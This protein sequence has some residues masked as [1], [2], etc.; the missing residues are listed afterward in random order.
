MLWLSEKKRRQ[1]FESDSFQEHYRWCLAALPA[2][3][4]AVL[5]GILIIGTAA[6]RLAAWPAAAAFWSGI[7]L[8]HGMALAAALT[9]LW[10][11]VEPGKRHKALNTGQ[12]ATSV[13]RLIGRA[14]WIAVA[15]Q[16]VS[17]LLLILTLMVLQPFGYTHEASPIIDYLMQHP[18]LINRLS[19]LVA[20]VVVAPVVEELFFRLVLFESMRAN[21]LPAPALLTSLAFALSHQSIAEIPSL[22]VLGLLLQHL[23]KTSGTLWQPIAVHAAFNGA[24]VL[25]LL[26]LPWQLQAAPPA[27]DSEPT[28]MLPA[29]GCYSPGDNS[30]CAHNSAPSGMIALS[31]SVPATSVRP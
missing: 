21:R 6:E 18:A 19:V 9:V 11:H 27:T 8:T 22:L 12:P 26:L 20:A 17:M 28:R 2:A 24:A 10:R 3:V 31:D 1:T 30:S 14:A 29:A 7:L 4:M 15:F 16:P 5:A 25:L 23:R 13:I